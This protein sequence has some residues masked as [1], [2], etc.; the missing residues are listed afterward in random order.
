MRLRP[1]F[2]QKT[3]DAKIQEPR[4]AFVRHQNVR[5][6]QIKVQHKL[7]MGRL[8]H[9]CDSQEKLEPCR[10]VQALVVAVAI[11]RPAVNILK[12][13]E[14]PPIRSEAP[15]QKPRNTRVQ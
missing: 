5:R 2:R 4:L 9:L 11:D 6:L 15:I 13:Q 12:H 1:R 7:L 10:C 8:H 3:C 14:R